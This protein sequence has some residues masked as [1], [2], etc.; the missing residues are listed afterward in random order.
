MMMMVK[1]KI[2]F[3]RRLNLMHLLLLDMC[4]YPTYF[5]MNLLAEI[6][7]TKDDTRVENKYHIQEVS[8][9]PSST[10]ISVSTKRLM[11]TSNP[12]SWRVL[13]PSTI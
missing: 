8:P 1:L 4:L 7:E 13:I 11:K 10:L 9:S 6:V 12:P 3:G 5:Y 2:N